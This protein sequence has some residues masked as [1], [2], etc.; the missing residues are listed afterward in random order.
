MERAL[1]VLEAT[2][3][4]RELLAEAGSLA[5]ATGAEL[6]L[7]SVLTEEGF[8]H[9]LE[10]LETIAEVEHATYGED[11]IEHL[12]TEFAEQMGEEVLEGRDVHYELRGVVDD[13]DRRVD[14]ILDAAEERN[15]DYVFLL[16]RKR[17]RVREA[18]FGDRAQAVVRSFDGYVV[19]RRE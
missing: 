9:D 17:N 18:L 4:G 6:I 13:G 3:K 15:C 2:E 16:S 1:V 11:A 19:V 14:E 12:L 8:E 7:L 10:T 5:E